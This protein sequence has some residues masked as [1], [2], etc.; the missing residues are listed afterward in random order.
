MAG[1]RPGR[2]REREGAGGR[3]GGVSG[4]GPYIIY[5]RLCSLY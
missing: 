4:L 5:G 2:E 3:G 1:G